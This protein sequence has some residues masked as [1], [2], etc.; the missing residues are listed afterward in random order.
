MNDLTLRFEGFKEQLFAHP[1]SSWLWLVIR[2]YL[3]SIWLS[4]GYEKLINPAWIGA[5]SGA[6][7][8]G[9]VAGALTKTTGAHPDVM[10]WYA[11][12]LEHCV[13]TSPALWAHMITFG[14]IAVGLG[15][16]FGVLTTYAT[17]GGL[18]MNFNFLLSGAV[19]INPVMIL[20]GMPLLLAYRVSGNIGL[21]KIFL[22]YL[23]SR[24]SKD[25]SSS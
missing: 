4:A 12:F 6:G 19:S 8:T 20:L 23:Q 3:G 5:S 21:Q 15:L 13:A 22:T 9:F 16:I 14:E 7:M 2:L 25:A 11:W 24:S 10:L 17:A 18:L 1:K